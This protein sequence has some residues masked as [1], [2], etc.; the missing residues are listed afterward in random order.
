MR[1]LIPLFLLINF[2]Y[3][4]TNIVVSI[5]P[6][7]TFVE[8][9]GGEKVNVTNMVRPGSDPHSYEP[10]P[11]QMKDIS[12][13]DIYFPIGLEFE[14][15]WLPKFTTQNKNMK[16]VEMTENVT[17]IEMA[18]HSHHHHHDEGH[19]EGHEE[20]GLPYEWAGIFDL[21]KGTYT[22]S[23]SKVEGKYADPKM[24]MLIIKADKKDDDLIE[25]YE[26]QAKNTFVNNKT[27]TATNNTSL[28]TSN[29]YYILNFD[30]SKNKTVFKVQIK[31]AGKYIFFTE[32]MPI[33]FEAE[34]HYFKD[35]SKK[36]IEVIASQPEEE[37]HGKDPHVWVSPKNVKIMAKNIYNTLKF[38]CVM[39][40]TI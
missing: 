20:G 25:F 12:K 13:A 10:K 9:I 16:F 40:S 23:F 8:K 38:Q 2:T 3:A 29:S 15:T 6:Q 37:H 22:W 18:K 34:E 33:E 26:E 1:F 27:K 31:Q 11:S 4:Q 35:S 7:K 14:N 5:L 39:L 19:E 36:D 28:E 17:Y 21:K 24:R 32:H 30:E